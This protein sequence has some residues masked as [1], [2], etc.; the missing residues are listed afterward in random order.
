MNLHLS[1]KGFILVPPIKLV[2][3]GQRSFQGGISVDFITKIRQRFLNITSQW[4]RIMPKPSNTNE[5]LSSMLIQSVFMAPGALDNIQPRASRTRIFKLQ[6]KNL[7]CESRVIYMH[8]TL[9]TM[10]VLIKYS[11]TKPS[12]IEIKVNH[13]VNFFCCTVLYI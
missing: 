11:K 10:S 5:N 2:N 13:V 6:T 8:S 1:M 9:G 7:R 4:F 3:C 12:K